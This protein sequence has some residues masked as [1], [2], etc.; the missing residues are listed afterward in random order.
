VIAEWSKPVSTSSQDS[1]SSI[2]ATGGSEPN[3]NDPTIPAGNAPPLPRWRLVA[4]AVAFGLWL[5]F[6]V[7]MALLRVRTTSH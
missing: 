1:M 3:W 5:V 4:A 2:N 6:L 7:A